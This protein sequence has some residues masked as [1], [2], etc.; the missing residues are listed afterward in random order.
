M[1]LDTCSADEVGFVQSAICESGYQIKDAPHDSKETGPKS[2]GIRETELLCPIP[3][4]GS[5]LS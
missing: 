3:A 5:R 2:M 1:S 4:H